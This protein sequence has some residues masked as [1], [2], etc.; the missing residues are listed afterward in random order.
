MVVLGDAPTEV[1]GREE[2]ESNGL[3]VSAPLIPKSAIHVSA[4]S[5]E[6]SVA[7]IDTELRADG[8]TAYHSSR[9]KVSTMLPVLPRA[10]VGMTPF[11]GYTLRRSQLNGPMVAWVPWAWYIPRLRAAVGMSVVE[12]SAL[13]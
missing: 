6:E 4:V 2:F 10:T 7:V 1:A 11:G 9:S 12:V 5:D 3:A 13:A 8:A